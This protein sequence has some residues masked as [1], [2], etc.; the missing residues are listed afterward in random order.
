[1][2]KQHQTAYGYPQESKKNHH[3]FFPALFVFFVFLSALLGGSP[4]AL[5]PA[6]IG[7]YFGAKY[8]ATNYGIT[9]TAKAWA[10]LISGWLSAYLVIQFGSFKLPLIIVA[11]FSLAAALLSNPK[12]MKAPAGKRTLEGGS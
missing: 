11:A 2:T 7:D 6:T 9:Y 3:G 4:F 5:Y 8:S 10:G 12:L 1:M